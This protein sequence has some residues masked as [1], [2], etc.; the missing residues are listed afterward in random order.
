[1]PDASLEHLERVG[2]LLLELQAGSREQDGLAGHDR[3][4]EGLE[5][6]LAQRGAGLDHVGDDVGD[7]ETDRGL[8]GAVEVDHLGGDAALEARRA[9]PSSETSLRVPAG[10]AKRKVEP[11][12]PSGRISSAGVRESSSMSWPVMRTSTVPEPTCTAMSRGRRWTS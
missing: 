11:A 3:F 7:P 8:H 12:K 6:G 10:A 5:P 2:G 4:A 9:P 1:A